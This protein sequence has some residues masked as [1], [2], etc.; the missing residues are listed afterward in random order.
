MNLL[1]FFSLLTL[2]KLILADPWCKTEEYY[3][4]KR[5]VTTIG[6]SY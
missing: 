1:Q 2:I 3:D 6:E 4:N 5:I